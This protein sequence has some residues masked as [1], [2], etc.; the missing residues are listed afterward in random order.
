MTDQQKLVLINKENFSNLFFYFLFSVFTFSRTV[1]TTQ[2]VTIVTSVLQG[3]MGMP[4]KALRMT[5]SSAPAHYLLL[6]TSKVL[7]ENFRI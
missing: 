1:V 6:L 2:L 7:T 5:V 3:T 4:Q